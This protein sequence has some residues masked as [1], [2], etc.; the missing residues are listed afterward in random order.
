MLLDDG[1]TRVV[2][3]NAALADGTL[4]IMRGLFSKPTDAKTA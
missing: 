3:L 1:F 4:R 2:N